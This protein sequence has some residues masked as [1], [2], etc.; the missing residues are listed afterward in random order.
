MKPPPA[1]K[2]GA[3]V[4]REAVPSNEPHPARWRAAAAFANPRAFRADQ[5][6]ECLHDVETFIG[7]EL[8]VFDDLSQA[9]SLGDVPSARVNCLVLPRCARRSGPRAI[10]QQV[11][12]ELSRQ[13]TPRE[14]AH[15]PQV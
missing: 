8:I 12:G 13:A 11:V 2:C 15:I 3:S 6:G 14:S 4:G 7:D 5:T 9:C 1:S 10:H